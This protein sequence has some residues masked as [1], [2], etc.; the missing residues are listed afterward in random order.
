MRSRMKAFAGY[1]INAAHI[2]EGIFY[3]E[4]RK[5]GGKKTKTMVTSIFSFSHFIF[6]SSTP[7]SLKVLKTTTPFVK[8]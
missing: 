7:H 4:V 1:K 6:R 3:L 5:H 8:G 2:N